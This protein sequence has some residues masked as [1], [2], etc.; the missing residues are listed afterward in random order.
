M[1][2]RRR[3][4]IAGVVELPPLPQESFEKEDPALVG[5]H[6]LPPF[7]HRVAD[8]APQSEHA[9][10]FAE[11]RQ[12][13]VDP[14]RFGAGRA[15]GFE[16]LAHGREGFDVLLDAIG[17][18]T[19]APY[20]ARLVFHEGAELL[21][22]LTPGFESHD[23]AERR[24]GVDAPEID[25]RVEVRVREDGPQRPVVPVPARPPQDEEEGPESRDFVERR[26]DAGRGGDARPPQRPVRAVRV[27]STGPRD[28]GDL[29]RL[30]RPRRQNRLDLPRHPGHL[31]RGI[32]DRLHG[33][34]PGRAVV[35][36]VA[37]DADHLGSDGQRIEER[38]RFRLQR[39]VEMDVHLLLPG[40]GREHS[41]SRAGACDAV[42]VQFPRTADRR[43][44][45]SRLDPL[46][47]A[48]IHRTPVEKP[49]LPE[50]IQIR[51]VDGHGPRVAAAREAV[52]P[53]PGQRPLQFVRRNALRQQVAEQ[54]VEHVPPDHTVPPAR[55]PPQDPPPQP[56]RVPAHQPAAREE[57]DGL[58]AYAEA[59]GQISEQRDGGIEPSGNAAFMRGLEQEIPQIPVVEPDPRSRPGARL[60]RRRPRQKTVD[61]RLPQRGRRRRA[62]YVERHDS[63]VG[64]IDGLRGT[65][66][67]LD[68]RQARSRRQASVPLIDRCRHG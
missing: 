68:G 16:H 17:E 45:P 15:Q 12:R 50:R 60:S 43:R 56:R 62:N 66:S 53:Q 23:A 63:D 64:R 44:Q 25:A 30:R 55:L 51:P 24:D 14:V 6:D 35:A 31:P 42:H 7:L 19:A 37:A 2:P 13:E 58:L 8:P 61:A 21:E 38:I 39:Q 26:P 65:G 11:E 36:M 46:R 54:A 29:M 18:E 10:V 9:A 20:L 59:V 5:A 41:A 34:R 3:E 40:E 33:R 57:A 52:P 4:R 28:D 32:R 47:D 1:P 22:I 67:T 48:G 27:L 49:P